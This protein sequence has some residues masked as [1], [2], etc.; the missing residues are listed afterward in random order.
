MDVLGR[1]LAARNI[2]IAAA[3]CAAADENRV[4]IFGQHRLQAVDALVADELDAEIENVIAFLVDHAFRKTEFRN[5]RTHHAAGFWILI[6]HDA[7]IAHRGKV[8]CHSE[9]GRATAH[10]RDALAVLLF[11]GLRHPVLDVTLE[12]GGDALQAAD[13]DGLS[14][15]ASAAACGLTWAIA[16]APENSR[17]HVGVPVD[18]VG[19]AVTPRRDQPDVFRNWRMRRTGPLTIYDFMEVVRDRNVGR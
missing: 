1:F 10:E 4:V 14:L 15:D 11:D 5:L 18:H 7:F 16:G 13:R 12:I 2:E 19:V 9:R 17:K 3:W 6:E 8:P